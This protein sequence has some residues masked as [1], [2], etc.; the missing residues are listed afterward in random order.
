QRGQQ[1][2]QRVGEREAHRSCFPEHSRDR[3][4]DVS[5]LSRVA[6]RGHT[7]PAL[8]MVRSTCIKNLRTGIRGW[9][10]EKFQEKGGQTAPERTL[11]PS[12][13]GPEATGSAFS[14]AASS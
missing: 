12:L 3:A 6:L 2:T 14:S 13:E 4:G 10:Q 7:S 1:S 11:A 5:P 9:N 8:R